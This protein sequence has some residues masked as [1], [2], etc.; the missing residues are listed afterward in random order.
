ME[1]KNIFDICNSD[2]LILECLVIEKII[3]FCL[4]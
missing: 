3:G 2:I 1:K 4:T